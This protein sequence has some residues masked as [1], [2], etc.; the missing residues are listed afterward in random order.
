MLKNKWFACATL[1]LTAIAAGCASNGDK[2]AAAPAD[3]VAPAPTSTTSSTGSAATTPTAPAAK[4]AA[5]PSASESV[6]YFDFDSSELKP[7]SQ[8]VVAAWTKY[9]KANPTTKVQ[10]QGNC[11][12]RGTREY[13]IAL[14]ERRAKAVSAALESAGVAAGQLSL[15]SFGK[16]HP[17]AQGHDEAAW[18]QNRRVEIVVQ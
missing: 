9:L 12:E 2:N 17:V 14:G 15:I 1:A 16:E 13:N 8:A 6:V 11:D 4:P 5:T 18:S 7:A 10:L 3:P